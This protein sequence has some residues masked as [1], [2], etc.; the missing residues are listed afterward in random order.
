MDKYRVEVME[1]KLLRHTAVCERT[2]ENMNSLY[3]FKNKR[4]LFLK[5]GR[6]FGA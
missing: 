5:N 2:N 1:I 3:V 6:K 4:R